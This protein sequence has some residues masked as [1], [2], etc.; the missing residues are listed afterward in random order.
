MKGRKHMS[1]IDLE[2]PRGLRVRLLRQRAGL[3][4]AVFG[5]HLH[6][7]EQKIKNWENEKGGAL[8]PAEVW[9]LARITFD[10]LAR[11]QWEDWLQSLAKR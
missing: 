10:A 11:Q 1:L 4:R 2:R 5:Q 3:D 9:L 8:M 7:S 6:A